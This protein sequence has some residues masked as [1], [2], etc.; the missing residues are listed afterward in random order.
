M[1]QGS[2]HIKGFISVSDFSISGD[3][4]KNAYTRRK[5]EVVHIGVFL[6]IMNFSFPLPNL[7]NI[8]FV[9]RMREN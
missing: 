5:L 6:G 3:R 1:E 8:G 2:E 7:R 9:S 4:N